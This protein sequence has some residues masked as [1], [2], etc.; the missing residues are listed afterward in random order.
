MH[1]G[2]SAPNQAAVLRWR[3]GG[4]GLGEVFRRAAAALGARPEPQQ[5]LLIHRS[6]YR[7]LGGH[8]S[9]S[10]EP[11]AALVRAL[12]RRRIVMLDAAMLW[13]G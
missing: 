6:L 4:T 10:D 11:H 13:R 3:S 9:A 2:E 1:D 8:D 5:G 7:S 12:G